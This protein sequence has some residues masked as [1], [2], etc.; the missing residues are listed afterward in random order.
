LTPDSWPSSA[1][2]SAALDLPQGTRAAIAEE[3]RTL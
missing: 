3:L 2:R 1:C